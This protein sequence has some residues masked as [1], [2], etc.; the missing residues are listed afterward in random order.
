MKLLSMCSDQ[1]YP[2]FTGFRLLFE[3][4]RLGLGWIKA[5]AR[6]RPID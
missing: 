6:V 4:R 1:S 3:G 2:E 5:R